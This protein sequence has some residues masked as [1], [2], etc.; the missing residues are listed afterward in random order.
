[1]KSDPVKFLIVDD[2][3]DNLASLRGL[4]E[5]DGLELL[6]AR[7]GAQALQLLEQH[8]FALALLDVQMPGMSGFELAEA[9]RK[10]ERTKSVPIIF[11][12]AARDKKRMFEGYGSGAVDYLY[13]PVDPVILKSKADVF[14]ELYRQRRELVN[15]LKLNEMFVGI[16]GH[17]L[18]N[19][20]SALLTG[21]QVLKKQV[22]A[23]PSAQKT[24]GRMQQAGARMNEM[25][26]QLLDLTR[27]RLGGGLG[28]VRTRQPVDV[29]ALAARAADELHHAAVERTLHVD[30]P[31]GCTTVGDGD[32]LLQAFSNLIANAFT[33]GEPGRPVTVK[34]HARG[35]D[36]LFE[37]SNGGTI[38]PEVLPS[39]FDPFRVR[40]KNSA[41]KGDGLGLGLF[42][43]Q[44]IAQA[45]GGEVT[46]ASTR[47][48]GTTFTVRLPKQAADAVPAALSAAE[49]AAKA[50]RKVVLVVDD[51][52]DVR[53]GLREAFEHEGYAARAAAN[54]REALDLLS[55]REKRPDAV[56]LDLMM[57]VL[58][59]RVVW[60]TMK[61]DPE[62]DR[63]PVIVSTSNPN[64]APRGAVVI[65]KPFSF[66]RLLAAVG[67][68]L[69]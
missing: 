15:A 48:Q 65:P 2:T 46:V 16:L 23:V 40:Q 67:A 4:L 42:I 55:E 28:F 39:L 54:G 12:T 27:A 19:P 47:E 13:K 34:C 56:V 45:H 17:D 41:T 37:V 36:V 32:R 10:N 59:G 1:M 51:D 62:L 61:A 14:C 53:E 20:L 25:I 18:R 26:Q 6:E 64:R 58:D 11:L 57:P 38:P 21:T 5:G 3:P 8:D 33:H 68:S 7:T 52:P 29:S 9:M 44:Q 66:E 30:A 49:V 24:L 50:P 31:P 63:I 69:R 43:A 60:E 35:A 22:E